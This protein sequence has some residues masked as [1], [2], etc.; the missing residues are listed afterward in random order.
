MSVLTIRAHRRFA[1]RLP[2]SL[3]KGREKAVS[4]LLI[5]ISQQGARISN[6]G[7]CGYDLGEDVVLSLPG[8][9]KLQGV[10]RWAHD[11]LA[12]I[13]LKKALY[14]PELAELLEK[15]RKNDEPQQRYGT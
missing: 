4:G 3:R 2:V 1:M 9:Q 15:N 10:V 12:G 7:Q 6:L 8:G 13:G 11:G 14:A 5:E